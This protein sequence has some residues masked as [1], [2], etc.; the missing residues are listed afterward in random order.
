MLE[1][2]LSLLKQHL[3]NE[4]ERISVSAQKDFETASNLVTTLRKEV[5]KAKDNA[6]NART[7]ESSIEGMVR[8]VEAKRQLYAQLYQRA[9]ELESERRSLTGGTR[10]VSLAEKPT[11]PYFPKKTPMVAAGLA[12]GLFLAAASCV[13]WDRIRN[14]FGQ[15][16]HEDDASPPR[17]NH[18]IVKPEPLEIIGSLPDLPAIALAGGADDDLLAILR[19]SMCAVGFQQG[20]KEL[21][22]DVLAVSAGRPLLILP[23]EGASRHAA[24]LTLAI[25]QNAAKKGNNV[26]AVECAPPMREFASAFKLSNREPTLCDVLTGAARLPAG[27]SRTSTP[28]FHVIAGDDETHALLEAG[29]IAGLEALIG[30]AKVYDLVLFTGPALLDPRSHEALRSL[31]EIELGT[32]VCIDGSDTR[33]STRAD[34]ERTL[35]GLGLKSAGAVVVPALGRDERSMRAFARGRKAT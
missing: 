1:A 30:W 12:L 31:A 18:D 17:R 33:D 25:G 26:L 20:A 16:D 19:R 15:L 29:D 4:I 9:S 5:D 28:G 24:F 3:A 22:T 35:A 6:A 27:I 21:A 11:R 32:L 2:S 23:A 8:D 34:A 13:L 7:D 14:G 10:L